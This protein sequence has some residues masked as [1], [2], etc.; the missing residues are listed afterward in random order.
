MAADTRKEL[1]QASNTR[2]VLTLPISEKHVL[3][4]AAQDFQG[5]LDGPFGPNSLRLGLFTAALASVLANSTVNVNPRQAIVGVNN[6]IESLNA[7]TAGMPV[8]EPNM[9]APVGKQEIPM[10]VFSDDQ[11]GSELSAAAHIPL[12]GIHAD[13]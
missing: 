4:S 9:E 2:Q 11:F 12:G 3:I 6:A 8:P 10:F 13:Y 5:E 7:S 1:Y